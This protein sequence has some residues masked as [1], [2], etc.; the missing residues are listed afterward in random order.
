M[1]GDTYTMR[2]ISNILTRFRFGPC[3]VQLYESQ[4]VE[5]LAFAKPPDYI[6]MVIRYLSLQQIV[7]PRAIP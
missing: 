2:R 1:P 7:M 6:E 4:Y 3:F 5:S